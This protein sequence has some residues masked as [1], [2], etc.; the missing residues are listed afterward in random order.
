MRK[1]VVLMLGLVLVLGACGVVEPVEDEAETT[2]QAVMTTEVSPIDSI[3]WREVDLWYDRELWNWL[4]DDL[5]TRVPGEQDEDQEIP[6]T[7]EVT[8]VH[9]QLAII[10]R[11]EVTGEET[12]ASEHYFSVIAFYDSHTIICYSYAWIGQAAGSFGVHP[13][14]VLKI[15]LP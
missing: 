15:T 12:L 2:T 3:S 8:L 9:R 6:L 13:L 4:D 7:E 10:L 14:L 1:I 11:N 5:A